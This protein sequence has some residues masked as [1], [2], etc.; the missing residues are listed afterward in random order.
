MFSV[1]VMITC[2][3]DRCGR[4]KTYRGS[5]DI[6]LGRGTGVH[7]AEGIPKAARPLWGEGHA[8]LSTKRHKTGLDQGENLDKGSDPLLKKF[9]FT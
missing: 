1:L 4:L 2:L 5:R 3:G 6:R 7:R 8:F 9:H